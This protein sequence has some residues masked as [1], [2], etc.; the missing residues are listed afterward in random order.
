MDCKT[1]Y[2]L[3]ELIELLE[4]IKKE[5]GDLPIKLQNSGILTELCSVGVGYEDKNGNFKPNDTKN[6]SL[7]R[8]FF[9]DY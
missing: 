9:I 2:T 1:E 7:K 5:E 3:S 4:E 6:E 8:V